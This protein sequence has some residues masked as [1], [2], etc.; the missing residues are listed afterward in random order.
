ML[1]TARLI[2]LNEFRLLVKDRVGLSMLLLAPVVIIA[3]AGFS[4]GNI[5]GSRPSAHAFSIPVID[6]DH[7]PVAQAIVATL[8]RE[9]AV[10]LAMVPNL[11]DARALVGHRARVPLAILFPAGTSAALQTGNAAQIV[12]YVDPIKRI[13]VAGLELHLSRMCAEITARAQA[14]ARS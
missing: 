6:R 9:S 7:G 14:A 13:E 11:A 12:L 5:Y 2:F 1:R 3:V 8:E 4:L 10:R